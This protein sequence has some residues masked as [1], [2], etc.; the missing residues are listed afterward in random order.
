[1]PEPGPQIALANTMPHAGPDIAEPRWHTYCI[2]SKVW[3]MCWHGICIISKVWANA[4]HVFCSF[5]HFLTFLGLGWPGLAGNGMSWHRK[6]RFTY[7][8]NNLQVTFNNL[9]A[10]FNNFPQHIRQFLPLSPVLST[11]ILLCHQYSLTE[12]AFITSYRQHYYHHYICRPANSDKYQKMH[13]LGTLCHCS[14]L[15]CMS[16]L[17]TLLKSCAAYISRHSP[18]A[19]YAI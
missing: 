6:W 13:Q 17:H 18:S 11:R 4:W 10:I 3:T 15:N 16:L 1:M 5:N 7:A 2:I 19:I 9:H 12:S 8:F 14:T